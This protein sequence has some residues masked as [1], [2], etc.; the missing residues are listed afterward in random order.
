MPADLPHAPPPRSAP[1]G[2]QVQHGKPAPDIFLQAAAGF[3]DGRGP[4]APGRCLVFEV[5]PKA[6]GAGCPEASAAPGEL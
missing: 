3:K 5:R 1:P 6:A 2:D 4:A